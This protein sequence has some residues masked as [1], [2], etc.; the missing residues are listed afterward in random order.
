[1]NFFTK[2][3]LK[4]KII[5]SNC[6]P[7]VLVVALAAV[8]FTGISSL[9]ESSHWVDH[10]HVVVQEAMEIEAAA[11]DMETGMRGYLLAGRDEFLDPYRNG[12][13]RFEKQV[14]D[15][16]VTVNDNP[17]QVQLL[18]EISKTV[19]EWKANVTETN[20]DLRKEIGDAQTMDDMADLVGE[21]RGK[22]Y[23]DA[24]RGQIATFRSREA[25]L[26]NERLLA[27]KSSTNIEDLR[28]SM[29]WI[30]HTH[31]VI[32]EAMKI[33]AAAVDMETGMR[34]YLLAG[35]EEFLDP[36]IAGREHFGT[37]VRTLK[38]TVSDNPAQVAL[39]GDLEGTIN[40]WQQDV[41]EPAIALRRRIGDAK[42]MNDMA[43]L[44][45]E[46]KG[47]V[48]FDRFRDQ[49]KTFRDRELALMSERQEAAAKTASNAKT[50][51]IVA[52][53][54]TLVIAIILAL[55]T[56]STIMG[57]FKELF[58]GLQSFSNHELTTLSGQFRGI[59]TDMT[60][61][62]RNVA[63]AT[64]ILARG[65]S[66]QSASLEEASA[67][68]SEISS[69]T[70]SNAEMAVTADNSMKTAKQVVTEANNNMSQLTNSMEEITQSSEEIA[71]IIKTIDEIA[72]QTNLLALNAAVE[73][74]RAGDAGKG[75]AVV[76]E[77]VRN[78]A[79]RCAEA[80]KNTADLIASTV[81]RVTE[82]SSL[83]TSTNDTFAQVTENSEE[84]AELVS[85][86]AAANKEQAQGISQISTVLTDLESVTQGNA[87][88]SEEISAQTQEMSATVDS[89]VNIIEG[90]TG[91]GSH[92]NKLGF[93]N[94]HAH[95]QTQF[96]ATDSMTNS[97]TASREIED[98]MAVKD[99]ELIKF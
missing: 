59:I 47:K 12:G 66:T 75:F 68:L 9:L 84:V 37:L 11:V 85:Q 81:D 98:M 28:N 10:T 44:I 29:E 72:F 92:F 93:D 60:N 23:F 79:Q 40:D 56:A 38:G 67:S 78:L 83:V 35:K 48:Y 90:D 20:I 13:K 22:I 16:Q 76:A 24:F 55:I 88:S 89:L 58:Q 18:N 21:A 26:L 91:G 52:V 1:M 63:S 65:A 41:T 57:K 87:A 39:L 34:G 3:G 6:A 17:A 61:G 64:D 5:T 42:S 15:L 96:S 36:Y 71:K 94:T 73:A 7:L 2:M 62:S 86:M 30:N 45:G 69:T 49:I 31:T 99:D 14:A 8:C 77:E 25:T 74:A 54:A 46:A 4:S 19:G 50:M 97:P 80:A 51:I 27:T 95:R 70:N 53:S 43:T 32:E 82:G 33:E